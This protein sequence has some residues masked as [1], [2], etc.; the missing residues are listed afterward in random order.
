MQIFVLLG[1]TSGGLWGWKTARF[2]R[3]SKTVKI[4]VIQR[5]NARWQITDVLTKSSSFTVSHG[6]QSD[7]FSIHDVTHT[8]RCGP[9]ARTLLSAP[10]MKSFS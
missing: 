5:R 2:L 1:L 6:R 7:H 10:V 3:L 8:L 4:L 9:K